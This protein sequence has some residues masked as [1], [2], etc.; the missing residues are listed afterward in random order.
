MKQH[1]TEPNLLVHE[2]SPYLLQHAYNPV[3]WFPWCDAAFEKA[4]RENKP[5]FLSVGYS[6]CHWCHVMEKES[7]END[8]IA[9][10]LNTEFV[11]VKVDRE[12][13]PDIDRFYMTYVQATSGRGGWP[14][15]V[16]LT[17]EKEPFFGGSY[18]PPEDRYGMAGFR[19]I[20]LSIAETWKADGAK[21]ADTASAITENLRSL[22]EEKPAGENLDETVLYRA[23]NAFAE[24]YDPVFGGFGGAPK[25]PRPAVLD[26]LLA[27]SYYTGQEKPRDMA[28]AT[29][30][31]MAD[32]GIHD[33][34]GIAGKGGGG[35]ARYSTDDRW[36]V[37]HFEKMLYDNAQL[38][39]TY[40]EAFMIS[41][42]PFFL[43]VTEDILNYVLCDMTD[44]GGGFHSAEDADS[45]TPAGDGGA[46]E[47]AF[48]LWSFDELRTLLDPEELELFGRLY[49]V[50]P[51]G[52][53]LEDPHGA[54][55]GLNVLARHGS[56]DEEALR[57]DMSD[58]EAETLLHSAREKLFRARNR[59]PRP[60]KDDKVLVSWN[61]LMISAFSKM[62]GITRKPEWLDA[63]EK[64][65]NF[66]VENLCNEQNGR[67]LR[68]YRKGEAGIEGKA[69]DYA[70]FSR[71]LLDLFE[72][73]LDRRHLDRAVQIM[74]TSIELFFDREE[75]G[76]FDTACGET[77]LPFRMKEIYDGAEPSSNSVN[78]STLYRL[79]SITGRNDFGE[80]AKKTLACFSGSIGAHPEQLPFMLKGLMTAFFGMR[81]V[82]LN[83]CADRNR[84]QRIR[85]EIGR[86]Y[87]P[88]TTVASRQE[89]GNRTASAPL[90]EQNLPAATLCAGMQCYPPAQDWESLERLLETTAP[91]LT[92]SGER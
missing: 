67:L 78:V 37:P 8:L 89:D 38:A 34:L 22:A 50:K 12:E 59:R 11:A 7:F 56:Q 43:D 2:H 9:R 42:D 23:A 62:F 26:F 58:R 36:H 39:L 54:F 16:W 51:E 28:F 33:H 21:M 44:E 66:I 65:A 63:A 53:V 24:Q 32:G 46:R 17:P 4:R 49:G 30:R 64:A 13:H 14:M 3:R 74:E 87:L 68:R 91:S 52:N 86:R 29:L 90:P 31:K 84:I 25:F 70:F 80:A 27:F 92:N 79:A 20:L 6:S 15:S 41:H 55:E 60:E 73:T 75:G 1:D 71:G 83:E 48:Y 61:G 77:T 85:E 40:A 35:F 10:L 18:F 45:A 47:G 81:E 69:D 19:R 88:D 72:A 5:V 76:F 57:R 82:T